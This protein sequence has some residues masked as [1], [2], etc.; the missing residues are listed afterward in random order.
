MQ[1]LPPVFTTKNLGYEPSLLHPTYD[2]SS[3]TKME[4]IALSR[5]KFA[6]NLARACGGSTLQRLSKQCMPSKSICVLSHNRRL[7]PSGRQEHSL[8]ARE[9]ALEKGKRANAAWFSSP[10]VRKF[11]RRN[12]LRVK[13]IGQNPTPSVEKGARG[14]CVRP[15]STIYCEARK[16]ITRQPTTP[17]SRMVQKSQT[18]NC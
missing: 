6:I 18:V 3:N 2:R 4:R 10:T 1:P 11:C 8:K 7:E 16:T 14:S 15:K 12:D 9:S 5:I 17:P 13:K